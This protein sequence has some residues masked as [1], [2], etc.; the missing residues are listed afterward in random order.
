MNI[1]HRGLFPTI[2]DQFAHF[3]AWLLTQFVGVKAFL[4]GQAE[5]GSDGESNDRLYK[6][7]TVASV[8]I[9]VTL[10]AINL[11]GSFTAM[12]SFAENNGIASSVAMWIPIAID[13]FVSLG[14]L[15][16]FGASLVGNR[17]GWVKLVVFICMILSA[18][19]NVEHILTD[20]KNLAH[21]LLGSIFPL[22]V[23]LT[24]EITAG[25]IRHYI[26]RCGSLKTNDQ[27]SAQID[28][29]ET[30]QATLSAE[31]EIER[32]QLLA[33]A[34]RSVGEAVAELEERRAALTS[35]N[36]GAARRLKKLK[37]SIEAATQTNITT[38]DIQI[39]LW[40]GQDNAISGREIGE[41]LKKSPQTGITKKNRVKGILNG[42]KRVS[43]NNSNP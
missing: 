22:G 11:I 29:L 41:R 32:A 36:E 10:I 16:I 12:R 4:F 33:A 20:Q 9:S 19:F 34:Q 18:F 15:V 2:G 24:S 42:G 21:Y 17:V 7:V 3:A 27:L 43:S 6:F 23:Y 37:A 5:H 13:G 14:I 25:Q 35:Q 30:Q 28:T 39:A 8:T 38:E 26:S 31:I 40:I 1:K